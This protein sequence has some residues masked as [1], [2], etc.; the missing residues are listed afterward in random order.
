MDSSEGAQIP[1]ATVAPYGK[2]CTNCAKARCKCLIRL[3]HDRTCERCQRLKRECVPPVSVR[4]KGARVNNKST[5]VQLQEKLED[6]V[7]LLKNQ[8]ATKP[9]GTAGTGAEYLAAVNTI[10]SPLSLIS[11]QSGGTRGID[12]QPSI[13]A[14][15]ASSASPAQSSYEQDI[16]LTS[17]S[18]EYVPTVPACSV[19]ITPEEAEQNLSIFREQ[20]LYYLPL[21]YMAPRTTARQVREE[22][23]FLWFNIMAI[24]TNSIMDQMLMSTAIRGHI[25]HKMVVENQKSVD[26]LLG[27]L[28]F[29]GWSHFHRR[30]RSH[31]TLMSSLAMSLVY[32]LGLH[33]PPAE[34]PPLL[35]NKNLACSSPVTAPPLVETPSRIP[36]AS[37]RPSVG[38][39]ERSMEVRRATL[40]CFYLTS[41][42]AHAVKR[43]KPL[44][45]TSVLDENLQVLS[46]QPECP[47]DSVLGVLVKI[48]LV[49]DQVA[50]ASWQSQE[51]GPPAF[52]I[53]SLRARL[54]EI[55]SQTPPELVGHDMLSN[56]ILQAELIIDEAARPK[57]PISLHNPDFSRHVLLDNT[58][59]TIA[60]C[61]DAFFE[62]PLWRYPGMPF[63][64]WG[65][66][67]HCLTLL[68][69]LSIRERPA[70]TAAATR[71]GRIELGAVCNSL[72]A[73]YDAVTRSG[74]RGVGEELDAFFLRVRR[75]LDSLRNSWMAEIVAAGGQLESPPDPSQFVPEGRSPSPAAPVYQADEAWL[76]DIFQIPWE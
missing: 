35:C 41:S 73:A 62:I 63:S 58:L 33:K 47:G 27:L 21:V 71:N 2:A 75:I 53:D 17:G 70:Y 5:T 54:Q 43:L 46:Q 8:V 51:S 52:Y 60:A 66:L 38:P 28:V 50:R 45:W 7:T 24:T 22:R 74:R 37:P 1:A 57:T 31:F 16:D 48:Q 12:V 72:A 69:H 40:A 59:S 32:D 26:L 67:G 55:K 13:S 23:P 9:A 44:E 76:T 61:L 25:A 34:P 6:L 19:Q 15:A 49:I 42:I 68:L 10:P 18:P 29:L 64:L 36:L 3:G 11:T 20:M 4:K 39:A 14:G 30:E 56:S 65:Q